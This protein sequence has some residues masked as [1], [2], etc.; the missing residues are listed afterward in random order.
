M[1]F[2][3]LQSYRNAS[4]EIAKEKYYQKILEKHLEKLEVCLSLLKVFLNNK[5]IFI[6]PTCFTKVAL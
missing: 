2:K 3:I 1:S 6:I 5:K 4:I